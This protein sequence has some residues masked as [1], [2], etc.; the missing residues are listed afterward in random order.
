MRISFLNDKH[1]K[2]IYIG[3][4]TFSGM[5]L[6]YYKSIM[7]MGIMIGDFNFKFFTLF[8]LSNEKSLLM[9]FLRE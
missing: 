3:Q 4:G 7:N 1:D 2:G 9:V 8:K 5:I 6:D